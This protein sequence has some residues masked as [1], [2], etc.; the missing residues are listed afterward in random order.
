MIGVEGMYMYTFFD[1]CSQLI[2]HSIFA[3][4]IWHG[5]HCANVTESA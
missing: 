2:R 3:V 4:A 1:Q 5:F